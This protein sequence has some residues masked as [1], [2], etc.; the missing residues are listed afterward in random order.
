MIKT[1]FFF[2]FIADKNETRIITTEVVTKTMPG[3]DLNLLK[4]FRQRIL[5]VIKELVLLHL[6]V[7]F[8]HYP[9]H[10]YIVHYHDYVIAS[11]FFY[12]IIV[13]LN[14]FTLYHYLFYQMNRVLR[15]LSF[16]AVEYTDSISAEG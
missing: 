6:I 15:A 7:V 12:L 10:Q 1:L 14:H 9:L 16:G 4:L 13:T 11:F 8:Y 2:F 5:I 3:M